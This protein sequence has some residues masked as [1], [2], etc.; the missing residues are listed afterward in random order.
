M[1][2]KRPASSFRFPFVKMLASFFV[3]VLLLPLQAEA[4]GG[5]GSTTE[6]FIYVLSSEEYSEV[7]GSFRNWARLYFAYSGG[8]YTSANA[9]LMSGYEPYVRSGEFLSD[10]SVLSFIGKSSGIEVS[11][12]SNGDY[13][14]WEGSNW[15]LGFAYAFVGNATFSYDDLLLPVVSANDLSLFPSSN[16][17]NFVLSL[18]EYQGGAVDFS[19]SSTTSRSTG[20]SISPDNDVTSWTYSSSLSSSYAS[21]VPYYYLIGVDSGIEF[22]PF[23]FGSSYPLSDVSS[24]RTER[25]H[26]KSVITADLSA[27]VDSRQRTDYA[28]DPNTV[29]SRKNSSPIDSSEDFTLTASIAPL[30]LTVMVSFP[31]NKE[32]TDYLEDIIHGYDSTDQNSDN[33]RFEDSRQELQDE[34]DSLFNDAMSGFGDLDMD[35]YS[36]G[37]FAAMQAAFSFV[38][39]FLQSLYVQMGDFGSIVTIGLVLLIASLVIGLYKYQVIDH[40]G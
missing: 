10:F 26:V 5:N 2:R 22:G 39:G 24:W 37:K 20:F 38:S 25:F 7:I 28:A 34:E 4:S 33:Q 30:S 23:D 15:R 12:S 32:V 29:D 17:D 21:S 16:A 11:L 36:I 8:T 35:D 9:A 31:A 27:V 13:V 14:T 1:A 18:Q 3:A 40:S 19:G 6:D